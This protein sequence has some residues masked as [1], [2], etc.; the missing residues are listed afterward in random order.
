MRQAEDLKLAG[1]LLDNVRTTQ[2]AFWGSH[3]G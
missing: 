1:E 2:A 3:R